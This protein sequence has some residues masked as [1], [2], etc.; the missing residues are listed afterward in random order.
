[1]M[2]FMPGFRLAFHNMKW[3]SYIDELG[4][5]ALVSTLK[6]VILLAFYWP[7][8]KWMLKC[9]S[10]QDRVYWKAMIESRTTEIQQLWLR[11][12]CIWVFVSTSLH[13]GTSYATELPV[14]RC[15]DNFPLLCLCSFMVQVVVLKWQCWTS[16]P[17]SACHLTCGSV[18][19]STAGQ[20]VNDTGLASSIGDLST[21]WF[22]SNA[23]ATNPL[24]R[25]LD[26]ETEAAEPCVPPCPL[27]SFMCQ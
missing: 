14:Y 26:R 9:N 21:F 27:V 10:I 22:D 18:H 8:S 7:E 23:F 25:G 3:R 11:W 17:I 20:N 4:T 1:M 6:D 16:S 19:R 5:L 24:C 13:A 12:W 2:Q 15:H